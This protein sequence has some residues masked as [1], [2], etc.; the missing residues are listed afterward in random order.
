MTTPVTGCA[1]SSEPQPPPVPERPSKNET[2]SNVHSELTT[3]PFTVWT[4]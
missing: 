1:P 3:R 4:A 2:G